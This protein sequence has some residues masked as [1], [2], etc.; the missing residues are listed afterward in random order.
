MG[1]DIHC[2]V[3]YKGVNRDRWS[4]FGGRINP[5]RNYD[6]FARMAGV[7]SDGVIVP[8]APLR[9]FPD[10]AAYAATHGNW[11]FI[12]DHPDEN[13]CTKERAEYYFQCCGSRYKNEE[14]KFVS[15]P[16]WHSHS[17]LTPDEFEAAIKESCGPEYM[18]ILAAMRCFESLGYQ[19]RLVFWF[20]N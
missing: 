3:E 9:G 11:I 4:H 16:D 1:C 17:W 13:C 6:L 7:R 8:V 14:R 5:G 10:D 19:A 18:A 20:D 15:N 2:Y 12:C